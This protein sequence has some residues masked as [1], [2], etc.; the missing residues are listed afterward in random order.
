MAHVRRRRIEWAH[1]QLLHSERPLAD[2]ALAAGF[3]DQGLFA[4]TFRRLRGLTPGKVRR[5][6]A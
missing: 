4:R 1:V 5:R 6:G 3:C 2:I